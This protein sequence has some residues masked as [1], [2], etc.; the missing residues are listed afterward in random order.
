MLAFK[1]ANNGT[2]PKKVIIYR[3]GVGEGQ[4]TVVKSSEVP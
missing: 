3:D 4:E 1:V 2:Y